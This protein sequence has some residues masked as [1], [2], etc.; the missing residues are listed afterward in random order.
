MRL[1]NKVKVARLL[2]LGFLLLMSLRR[3]LQKAQFL[4]NS[5]S[6]VADFPLLGKPGSVQELMCYGITFI[7][8]FFFSV[9]C[10]LICEFH[11]LLGNLESNVRNLGILHVLF[12]GRKKIKL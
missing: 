1:P 8:I 7:F 9:G 10:A 5:H 4:L 2:V 11:N 3:V 6:V 12:S